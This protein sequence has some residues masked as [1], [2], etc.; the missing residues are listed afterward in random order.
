M[1]ISNEISHEIT[2][3]AAFQAD[4]D[5]LRNASVLLELESRPDDSRGSA[6]DVD[7]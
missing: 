3:T 7:I 5:S 4:F 2:K 1:T 6:I